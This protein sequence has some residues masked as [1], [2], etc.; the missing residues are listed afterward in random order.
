MYLILKQGNIKKNPKLKQW[1]KFVKELSSSK[2]KTVQRAF[3]LLENS[4]FISQSKVSL[5]RLNLACRLFHP[6]LSEE[7]LFPIRSENPKCGFA[8]KTQ[9]RNKCALL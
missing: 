4:N 9:P 3:F 1:S 7:F 2:L 5:Q 6:S 8:A